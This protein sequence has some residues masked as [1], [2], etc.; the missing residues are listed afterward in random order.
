MV[1][2]LAAPVDAPWAAYEWPQAAR[3][4]SGGFGALFISFDQRVAQLDPTR[5]IAASTSLHAETEC[6]A[7]YGPERTLIR[8]HT[9]EEEH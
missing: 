3:E 1:Q 7:R 2:D 8:R 9:Y 5:A 4:A 6:H